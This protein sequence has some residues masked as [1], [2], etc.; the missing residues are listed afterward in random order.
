MFLGDLVPRT[1]RFA[2]HTLRKRGRCGDESGGRK[3]NDR[4]LHF[5]S[6]LPGMKSPRGWLKLEPFHERATSRC[7]RFQG[8]V[9]ELE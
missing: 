3:R 5:Q 9:V 4:C 1:R 8:H 6:S 7:E 2:W